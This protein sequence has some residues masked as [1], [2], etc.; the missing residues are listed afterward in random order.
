MN[1]VPTSAFS[2]REQGSDLR[3]IADNDLDAS[4]E[5]TGSE[6]TVRVRARAITGDIVVRRAP[7][8]PP[9]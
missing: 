2:F 1:A 5:P 9:R 6:E 7:P 4:G 3:G 8:T